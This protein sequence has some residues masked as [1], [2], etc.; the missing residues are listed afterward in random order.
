MLE[1]F[2][3]LRMSAASADGDDFF[4]CVHRVSS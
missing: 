2:E 1:S 4:V 3:D